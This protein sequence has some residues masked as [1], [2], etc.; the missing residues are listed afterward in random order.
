[1]AL[2]M[3]WEVFPIASAGQ[4]VRDVQEALRWLDGSVERIQERGVLNA[5]ASRELATAARAMRARMLDEADAV[6]AR[7]ECW[8]ATDGA[9]SVTL[10]PSN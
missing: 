6:T 3:Q 8:S 1:M 9:I 10:T 4:T 7:G 5:Y 2:R